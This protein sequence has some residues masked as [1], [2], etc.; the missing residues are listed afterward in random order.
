MAKRKS[1]NYQRYLNR[2]KSKRAEKKGRHMRSRLAAKEA[3]TKRL[4]AVE[5]EIAKLQFPKLAEEIIQM[6]NVPETKNGKILLRQE[7]RTGFL[8]AFERKGA[9]S[10]TRLKLK[11]KIALKLAKDSATVYTTLWK[12]RNKSIPLKEAY[13]MYKAAGEIMKKAGL[14]VKGDPELKIGFGREGRN[15]DSTAEQLRIDL[16]RKIN[17]S[18]NPGNRE[19]LGKIAELGESLV[20][21]LYEDFPEFSQVGFQMIDRTVNEAFG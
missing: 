10:G 21:W 9:R 15:L 6:H 1:F 3:A 17:G 13:E 19:E 12:Y 16:G 20:D 5:A 7:L 8:K 11:E 2:L 14:E 4:Q 18:I